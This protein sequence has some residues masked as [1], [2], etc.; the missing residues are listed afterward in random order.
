[1]NP[2]EIQ[3]RVKEIEAEIAK[4]KAFANA[5]ERG[6]HDDEA[7]I[8]A[9]AARLLPPQPETTGGMFRRR[10]Q[11]PPDTRADQ[12]REI[13]RLELQ[14]K[15]YDRIKELN[16]ELRELQ[17]KLKSVVIRAVATESRESQDVTRRQ[18]EGEKTWI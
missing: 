7:R 17:F 11:A 16:A 3:A 15:A 14:K 9:G 1:V 18:H 4:L 6:E 2:S 12:V 13:Q 8:A 5:A 10:T